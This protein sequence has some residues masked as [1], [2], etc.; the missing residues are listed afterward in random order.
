MKPTVVQMMDQLEMV[1]FIKSNGTQCRFCSLISDTPVVKIRKGNP[2][3]GLRKVSRK[4]GLINANFN[5]SVRKRIADTL[6]VELKE[7]EYVNGGTWYQHIL[8]PDQKPL[9]LV[10]NKKT[11][12]NGKYYVQFFPRSSS[13]K[14]VTPDGQVIPDEQVNPWLYTEKERPAFKPCVISIDLTNVRQFKA[15]GVIVDLPDLEAAEQVLSSE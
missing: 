12:D 3:P 8:T 11:P 13:S 9:P 4:N 7:V 5:T 10:V 2:F 14:Y 1:G 15:S 6:G